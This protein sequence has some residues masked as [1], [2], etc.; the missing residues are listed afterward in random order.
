MRRGG[1][2]PSED[3]EE[4]TAVSQSCP[5]LETGDLSRIDCQGSRR[6]GRLCGIVRMG[7]N[8]WV[9]TA[10]PSQVYFKILMSIKVH[11]NSQSTGYPANLLEQ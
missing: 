5:P 10:L 8:A 2:V 4:A 7:Y 11:G 9:T 1:P 3:S 6:S